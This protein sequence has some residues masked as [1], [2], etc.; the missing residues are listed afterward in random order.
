[1]RLCFDVA[2]TFRE[3]FDVGNILRNKVFVFTP[4][5]LLA[6]LH[7]LFPFFHGF[8][9]VLYIETKLFFK[10]LKDLILLPRT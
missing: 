10:I 8:F 5:I 9:V 4:A 6:I 3:S 2:V 7:F 1:M